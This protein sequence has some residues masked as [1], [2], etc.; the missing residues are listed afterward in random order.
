M[1]Q[2]IR[3]YYHLLAAYALLAKEFLT[4]ASCSNCT[5]VDEETVVTRCS[6]HHEK[7]FDVDGR[8]INHLEKI[9]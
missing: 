5:F 1:R 9:H 8:I 6:K 4:E 7:L 2:N 3:D